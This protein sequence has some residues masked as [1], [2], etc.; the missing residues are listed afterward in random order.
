MIDIV[1]HGYAVQDDAVPAGVVGACRA[2]AS[3]VCS[4]PRRGG[5]VL[6]RSNGRGR[7]STGLA[8]S[9]LVVVS[10]LKPIHNPASLSA[11]LAWPMNRPLRL[12]PCLGV[13]EHSSG[14]PQQALDSVQR[15][16]SHGRSS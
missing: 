15:I 5:C 4:G 8:A 10:Q 1:V 14:G 2:C 7:C 3:R 16:G 13:L 9:R 6:G 12:R 11:T